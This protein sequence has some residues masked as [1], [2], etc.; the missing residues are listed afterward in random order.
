MAKLPYFPLYT[1]DFISDTID[2]S[3]EE[4]GAYIRVLMYSWQKGK[5]SL[6]RV[7]RIVGDIETWEA[8]S[9]YFQEE[10][11]L[12][13][14]PRM[15]RERVKAK[16]RH[17]KAVKAN[18]ARWD[19]PSNAPSNATSNPQTHPPAMLTHNSQPITHN[20]EHR[21]QEL[22]DI[23]SFFPD[24]FFHDMTVPNI[25]LKVKDDFGVDG[26]RA[27]CEK[28]AAIKDKSKLNGAYVRSI[29]KN[30]DLAGIAKGTSNERGEKLEWLSR[31][32]CVDLASK[33][34]GGKTTDD[35]YRALKDDK[36]NNIKFEKG[37]RYEGQSVWVKK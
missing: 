8:I 21:T 1:S 22:N 15:E 16:G 37:H 9:H 29:I 5:V 13:F 2:L 32:Q 34:K 10:N 26:L 12:W 19:A 18:S 4:M 27:M 14:N 31:L 28:V 23:L 24:S 7:V 25:L 11:G 36:G 33:N 35:L 30:T 17:D 20:T 3:N 6:D